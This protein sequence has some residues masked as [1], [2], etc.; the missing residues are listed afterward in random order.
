MI[1]CT[2]ES[3]L[4]GL[5][6]YPVAT[7]TRAFNLRCSKFKLI[8]TTDYLMSE[9]NLFTND[10]WSIK[11]NC[12]DGL[13]IYKNEDGRYYI[14]AWAENWDDCWGWEAEITHQELESVIAQ[15]S[16]SAQLMKTSRRWYVSPPSFKSPY[17]I[18]GFLDSKDGFINSGT[19]GIY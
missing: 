6:T 1:E 13:S 18:E 5:N 15:P 10:V 3:Y 9:Q 16:Q 4:A 7:P 14:R 11:D 12:H 8:H 19:G 2:F 17:F